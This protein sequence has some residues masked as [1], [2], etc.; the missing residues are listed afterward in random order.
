MRAQARCRFR[1]PAGGRRIGR[2]ER[3]FECAAPRLGERQPDGEPEAAACPGFAVHADFAPHDGDQIA[4]DGQAEPGAAEAPRGA[5]VGL[6]ES[7]EDFRLHRRVHTH[8]GVAH[9]DADQ[10]AGG[11]A[12]RCNA[13][14][15]MAALGELQRVADQ[16]AQHLAQAGGVALHQRGQALV[17]RQVDR[18]S[19]V[20]R[21]RGEQRELSPNGRAQIECSRLERHLARFDLREIENVVQDRQQRPAGRLEQA[22]QLALALGQRRVEQHAGDAQHAV[23]RRA[24]FVAHI[25]QE[26]RSDFHRVFGGVL[27]RNGLAA[28][29]FQFADVGQRDH[30]ARDRAIIAGEG[31]ALHEEY[32]GRLVAVCVELDLAA[33]NPARTQQAPL[34][35]VLL[36]TGQHRWQLGLADQQGAQRGEQALKGGVHPQGRA[37][38]A[39]DRDRVR[40]RLEQR[41]DQPQVFGD[42]G[43]A[44]LAFGDVLAGAAIAAEPAVGVDQRVAA[45]RDPMKLAVGGLQLVL[46]VAKRP[47][48]R[49]LCLVLGQFSRSDPRP[50]GLPAPQPQKAAGVGH[51]RLD[52]GRDEDIA[53]F[54]VLFPIPVRRNGGE[55]AKARF[56]LGQPATR[57]LAVAHQFDDRVGQRFERCFASGQ[58]GLACGHEHAVG[59]GAH[60]IDHGLLACGGL[61]QALIG[62]AQLCR[63]DRHAAVAH[64]LVAFVLSIGLLDGLEEVRQLAHQCRLRGARRGRFDER[65][66]HAQQ[67]GHRFGLIDPEAAPQLPREKRVHVRSCRKL[68]VIV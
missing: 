35:R 32:P 31:G 2:G 47:P 24:H 23:H 30:E 6:R 67:R 1:W 16:I 5:V 55:G 42:L 63:A 33:M 38:R 13:D 46:E 9:F 48:L 19:L 25:G 53:Q 59:S 26:L 20:A 34:G 17:Q 64:G 21:W 60:R 50:L 14:R 15:D 56:A 10:V 12:G 43:L 62:L 40:D 18:Q 27:C 61:A 3:P 66:Q 36:R 52:A 44:A 58:R 8:A 11:A 39:A 7:V 45:G 57:F 51:H 41:L 29:L 22:G 54:V 28:G 65:G 68:M 37:A 4:A 49:E